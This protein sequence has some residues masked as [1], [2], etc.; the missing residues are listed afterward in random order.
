MEFPAVLSLV[1]SVMQPKM[2]NSLFYNIY[3]LWLYKKILMI[4]LGK[5]LELVLEALN[6]L[7]Q[8][9]EPP[10]IR[11]SLAALI[12]LGQKL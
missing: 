12:C 9:N 3:W 11:A 6:G 8:E 10:C 7:G 1:L 2:G 5:L 4:A